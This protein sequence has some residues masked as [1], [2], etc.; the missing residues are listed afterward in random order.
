ML[1]YNYK[2]KNILSYKNYLGRYGSQRRLKMKYQILV[3]EY[4]SKNEF[5]VHGTY[6]SKREA[7]I[8]WNDLFDNAGTGQ[9]HDAM[10]VEVNEGERK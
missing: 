9:I 2:I 6:I 5:H 4:S 10:I 1:V 7:R 8:A 3:Q